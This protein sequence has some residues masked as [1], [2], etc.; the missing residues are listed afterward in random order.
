MSKYDFPEI[1]QNTL[2]LEIISYLIS[3]EKSF[4]E[5]KE[6][7]N[8]TD[9]NISVQIKKMKEKDIVSIKKEFVKN[10]PKTT[11]TLTDFGLNEFRRYISLLEDIL[12][13]HDKDDIR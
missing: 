8:A 4:K 12:K 13:G 5:I 3:G 6:L 10:K 1:F 7:T 11:Y 2:R 9:G